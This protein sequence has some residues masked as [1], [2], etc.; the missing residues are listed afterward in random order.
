LTFEAAGTPEFAVAPDSAFGG[1]FRIGERAFSPTRGG[2]VV[3]AWR[4]TDS[5][6]VDRLRLSRSGDW[7]RADGA[8]L[9]PVPGDEAPFEGDGYRLSYTR[10]WPTRSY[11]PETGLQ[12]EVIPHA[13]FGVGDG[14]GSAEA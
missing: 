12:V 11:D 8:P 1:D 4:D 6:A 5:G 9:P 2:R 14:G 7:L 10:G 13:G 3:E